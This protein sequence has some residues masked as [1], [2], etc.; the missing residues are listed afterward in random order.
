MSSAR[1]FAVASALRLQGLRRAA[2]R[3]RSFRSG[4]RAH[5]TLSWLLICSLPPF[6]PGSA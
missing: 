1:Y 5:R 6:S 2:V 3:A 4:S